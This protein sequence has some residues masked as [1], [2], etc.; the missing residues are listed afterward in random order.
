MWEDFLTHWNGRSLFLESSLI[1]NIDL[2]LH[3]DA[4]GSI[5]YGE[6][7]GY[8]W[9]SG[10][11]TTEFL[12]LAR[13]TKSSSLLELVPIVTSAYLLGA[14]WSRHRII[15]FVTIKLSSTF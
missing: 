9:F 1:T 8:R 14:E 7:F 6:I 10:V 3:T 15:F 13:H 12:R 5:G 11:W 2:R 4:A